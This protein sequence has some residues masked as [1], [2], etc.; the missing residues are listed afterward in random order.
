MCYAKR[1]TSV[2]TW[3][4]YGRIKHQNNFAT[5]KTGGSAV[6]DG[7]GN[8]WAAPIVASPNPDEDAIYAAYGSNLQKFSY[9]ES[10]GS[11]TQTAHGFNFENRYSSEIGGFGYSEL[12]KKLWYV[13]L[14]NG[15]FIYSKDG[16]DN[17]TRSKYYASTPKAN[18]QY[19]NYPKNQSVIRASKIDTS[20]VY[21]AGVGNLFLISEDNGNMFTNKANGLSVTRIRDFALSPDEQFIFAACGYGGAWVYSVQDNYWYQMTDD[22]IPSVDFTDVEFISNKNCVRFGTYGSGI[23]E[24]K[25]NNNFYQVKGPDRLE[26]KINANNSIELNWF[27]NA[28]DEDGFIIERAS[29][30][31]FV[32]IDTVKADV[33]SYQEEISA[34]E[35]TFYY[36][37]RAYKGDAVSNHTNLVIINTPPKGYISTSDWEIIDFSSEEIS[38]EN[39]PVK[40]AVDNN[41][42]TYW[43]T[44]YSS[45]QPGHPHYIVLD[46]GEERTLA[47]F[48]YLP[49][50]DGLKEGTIA[51]YELYVSNDPNIWGSPVVSGKFVATTKL[52]EVM[53]DQEES[54]RYVKLEAL[55]SITGSNYTSMAEFILLY[56]MVPPDVP[57]N[58]NA[59]IFS[60]TSVLLRWQDNSLNTEGYLVEQLVGDEYSVVATVNAPDKYFMHSDQEPATL[61]KYRIKAFNRGGESNYTDE[62]EVTTGGTPTGLEKPDVNFNVY[63][64][65]F[66]DRLNIEVPVLKAESSV[67]LIDTRGK[68]VLRQSIQSGDT[69]IILNT[70]D[71]LPG[72]YI[73]ECQLGNN[74]VTKKVIKK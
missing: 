19:Y 47:G 63:P 38:S 3:F 46:L 1:E 7:L 11:I 20:K 57:E 50:Q 44:L 15:A 62:I 52:K 61:Y 29:L 9:D 17:W 65:P 42:S 55:S 59:M 40:Y 45:A 66:D 5:G 12:N 58:L 67:K 72:M 21:Y 28:L 27:D 49:R 37:V 68:V 70:A 10:S 34:Y 60:D 73:I 35:A 23:I 14:N 8:W 16:G 56:Q 31:E 54:G 39:S 33:T 64:N 25:L 53:F 6:F 69:F 26:G 36:R 48:R 4:Y 41:S 13:A 2:W 24:F 71:V 22:P 74:R 43:H 32:G 30:G 51:D 18:D